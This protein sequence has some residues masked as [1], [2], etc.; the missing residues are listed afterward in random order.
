VLTQPWPSTNSKTARGNLDRAIHY[1]YRH[2]RAR[3]TL[4][5][6]DEQV[7]K[8]E[9]AV[10][11]D[12]PVARNRY[13]Q[14]SGD[15]RSVNRTLEAQARAL[16]GWKSYATNLVG[17]PPLFVI[18]S[19]HRL[20]RAERAFRMSKHDL[21]ARPIHHRIPD[22]IEAHLTIVFAAMAVTQLIE[23]QTGWGIEK[24]V[25]TVRRYRTVQI[26]AGRQILT[27]ADPVPYNVA[28]V[29]AKINN[30]DGH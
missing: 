3:R 6:I 14:L 7:R 10:D 27:A 12:A 26:R 5:G 18:D 22:S 4:R 23:R 25:N 17:Q 13:I 1:Q 28:H 29:L 30:G 20:R 9:S 2:D 15:V 19:F 21:E 16:A 24:F 8:A 11:S